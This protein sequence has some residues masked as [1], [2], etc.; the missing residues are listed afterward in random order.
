MIQSREIG[1]GKLAAAMKPRVVGVPPESPLHVVADGDFSGLS[2]PFLVAAACQEQL[3]TFVW[4]EG[5]V[6]T[7]VR[8][9]IGDRRR[10][11][12]MPDGKILLLLPGWRNSP[13]TADLVEWWVNTLDRYTVELDSPVAPDA[14]RRMLGAWLLLAAMVAAGAVLPWMVAR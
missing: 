13:A 12:E 14:R 7:E 2:Q 8:R 4:R 5:L 6:C 9:M 11:A 1:S 10:F 3:E